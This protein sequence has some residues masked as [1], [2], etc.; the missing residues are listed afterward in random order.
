MLPADVN[1]SRFSD[2]A[3]RDNCQ[4]VGDDGFKQAIERKYNIK[5]G[6]AKRGRP[7]KIEENLVIF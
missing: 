5:I 3:G 7:R 1:E 6:Q 2:T 4:P